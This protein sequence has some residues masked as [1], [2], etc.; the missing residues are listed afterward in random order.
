MKIK[1]TLNNFYLFLGCVGVILLFRMST[2]DTQLI[3]YVY[4]LL[5]SLT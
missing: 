1:K 5:T 4:S 2:E 3:L